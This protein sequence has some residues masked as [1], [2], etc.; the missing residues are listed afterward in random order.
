MFNEL[1]PELPEPVSA[2]QKLRKPDQIPEISSIA[3]MWLQNK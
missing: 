3:L 2:V 1:L